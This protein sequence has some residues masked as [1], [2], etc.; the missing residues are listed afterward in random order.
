[1]NI[2]KNVVS[3]INVG[4]LREKYFKGGCS[5]PMKTLMTGFRWYSKKIFT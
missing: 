5:M 2:F 4:S 3:F 1:M